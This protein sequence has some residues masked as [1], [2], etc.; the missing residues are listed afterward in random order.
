MLG[1]TIKRRT[2]GRTL[3][4]EEILKGEA[5]QHPDG[6]EPAPEDNA[7]K[8][9]ELNI[10]ESSMDH[11]VMSD[12][13]ARD[14]PQDEADDGLLQQTLQPLAILRNIGQRIVSLK[15][16]LNDTFLCAVTETNDFIVFDAL[17]YAFELVPAQVGNFA[18]KPAG[19]FKRYLTF[20]EV[21]SAD[22]Q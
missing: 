9:L 6:D 19:G 21:P 11:S 1:D 18:G 17:C 7:N 20:S 8:G 15:W 22:E 13:I 14:L 3:N 10:T 16:V 2:Y 12:P 5:G 4:L